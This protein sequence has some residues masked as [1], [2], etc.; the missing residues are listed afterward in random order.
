MELCTDGMPIRRE[1][2]KLLTRAPELDYTLIGMVLQIVLYGKL[3]VRGRSTDHNADACVLWSV[4]LSRARVGSGV[5]RWWP[6]R[7]QFRTGLAGRE[8]YVRR[9]RPP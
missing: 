3:L 5:S 6:P 1:T 9:P 4:L 8:H 7:L 2:Y